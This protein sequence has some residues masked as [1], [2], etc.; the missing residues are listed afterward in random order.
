MNTM[1]K[2]LININFFHIQNPIEVMDGKAKEIELLL[3]FE[4]RKDFLNG[5]PIKVGLFYNDPS[6][7]GVPGDREFEL[8]D[9]NIKLTELGD[10]MTVTHRGLEFSIPLKEFERVIIHKVILK[11]LGDNRYMEYVDVLYSY[12]FG[13]QFKIEFSLNYDD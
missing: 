7:V 5:Y 8:N 3:P 11:V 6:L 13:N 4:E 1:I 9:V 2:N 12:D 10:W